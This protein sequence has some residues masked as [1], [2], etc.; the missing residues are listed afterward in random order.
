LSEIHK[1]NPHIKEYVYAS[2]VYGGFQ[3]AISIFC[4]NNNIKATIFCAKRTKQH[5]NTLKCIEHGANVVEVPYGYL[6]V[7]E[8]KAIEY[9]IGKHNVEKIIQ[10]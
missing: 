7:V 3:I 2:P 9:C 8:K 1:E 5:A 4:K 10:G 6:S